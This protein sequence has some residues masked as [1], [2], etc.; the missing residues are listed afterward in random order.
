MKKI[1]IL[2]ESEHAIYDFS[3]RH[4]DYFLN[5]GFEVI[6]VNLIENYYKYDDVYDV[7]NTIKRCD[8]LISFIDY[9]NTPNFF[10]IGFAAGLGK[11]ILIICRPGIELPWSLRKFNY[12]NG[13]IDDSSIVYEI[14]RVLEKDAGN[15]IKLQDYDIKAENIKDIYYSNYNVFEQIEA[16]QFEGIVLELFKRKGYKV[17]DND[18]D[19]GYDF[20]FEDSEGKKVIV[21]IKKYNQNFRVS[22]GEI[23]KLLGAV[24]AYKAQ[25]GL[26]LSSSGFTKSAINFAQ[27]NNELIRLWDMDEM[28]RFLDNQ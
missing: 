25:G 11:Q 23:H 14:Q 22:I 4:S 5:N 18:N 24:H 2:H 1:L 28:F 3:K 7:Q 26:L 20:I 17:F 9:L 15:Y 19:Y 10:E 8:I 27:S 6:N 12:I 13:F 16:H 21:E